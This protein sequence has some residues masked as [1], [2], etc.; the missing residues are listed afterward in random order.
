M[1]HI[2][3][4]RARLIAHPLYAAV[5]DEEALRIFMRAHVFC[6]FDFMT[7]LKTLQRKLTCV[8]VPWLPPANREA[9]RLVNEIVLGEESDLHPSGGYASHYDLY[10]EAMR[11]CGADTTPIDDVLGW[12]RTGM[13]V[14]AVLMREELPRGVKTF[15]TATLDVVQSN[16]LHRIVAY[17]TLG[18]EDVIPDMFRRLVQTLADDAP[19]R[20]QPFLYYLDRHIEVDGGQ[21]GPMSHQLLKSVC[22][23]DPRLWAEG[24]QAARTALNARIALWDAI[25]AEIEKARA[26]DAPAR[27]VAG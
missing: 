15:V 21:H 27:R 25:L 18:R 4:L 17:F 19:E 20:W 10:H 12:L 22:G 9:S 2:E 1:I 23:D 6:V 11:A 8:D 14:R 3:D 26:V 16:D 5:S 7:L 24:E 13:N